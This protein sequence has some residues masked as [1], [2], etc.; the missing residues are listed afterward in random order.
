M[1]TLRFHV[2]VIAIGTKSAIDYAETLGVAATLPKPLN[3]G[4]LMGHVER[5]VE[6]R[7]DV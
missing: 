1:L 2:A 4:A 7:Q 6:A 3:V 5:L